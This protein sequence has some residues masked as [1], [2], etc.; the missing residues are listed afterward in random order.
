M[1]KIEYKFSNSKIWIRNKFDASEL[2]KKVLDQENTIYLISKLKQNILLLDLFLIELFISRIIRM[3]DNQS[4]KEEQ[5]PDQSVLDLIKVWR[6]QIKKTV[7]F[8]NNYNR[9]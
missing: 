4:K 6:E 3:G 7:D 9:N 2:D 1:A 8:C 5:D